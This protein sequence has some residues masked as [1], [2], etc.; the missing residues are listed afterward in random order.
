MLHGTGVGHLL[1]MR[2][3]CQET[4]ICQ[5]G[6]ISQQISANFLPTGNLRGFG[7]AWPES[8]LESV[9]GLGLISVWS[10]QEQINDNFD[11]Q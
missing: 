10:T 5:P 11:L 6:A 3:F 7:P 8:C 2:S 1:V 4:D 9:R